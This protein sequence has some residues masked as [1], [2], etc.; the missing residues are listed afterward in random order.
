MFNQNQ[1]KISQPIFMKT[2]NDLDSNEI[3]ITM[4]IQENYSELSK[5]IGEVTITIPSIGTPQISINNVSD[6]TLALGQLF[7]NHERDFH[8]EGK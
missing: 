3:I 1:F 6:Y 7:K 5:Y 8:C 2:E 4:T